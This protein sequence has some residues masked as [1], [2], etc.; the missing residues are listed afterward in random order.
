MEIYDTFIN[1][2]FR[3]FEPFRTILALKFAK[4]ANLSQKNIS[5]FFYTHIAFLNY[6]INTFLKQ[7]SDEKAKKKTRKPF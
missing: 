5:S 4:K 1:Y 3:F 2:G 6:Q 7:K